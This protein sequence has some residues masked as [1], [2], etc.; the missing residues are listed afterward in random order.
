MPSYPQYEMLDA[1][2][3]PDGD[4]QFFGVN[5]YLEPEALPIGFVQ[6]AHDMRFDGNRATVRKGWDF[7][8][9]LSGISPAFTYVEGD[10]EV[11]G[12]GRYSDPDD[13]NKDWIVAVTKKKAIIWN[14][15][16]ALYV[17]Y[18]S[19]TVDYTDVNTSNERIAE[20]S[21]NLV[22]GTPIMFST[23]DTLPA[24]LDNTTTYYAIRDNA[25]EFK[26]A[27]SLANALAGT[28]INLSTQGAGTHTI[29]VVMASGH[30]CSIVQAFNKVYIF[31][32]HHRPMVWDGNTAATGYVVNSTFTLLSE[33]ASGVGDPFPSTSIA[34]YFNERMI[35]VQPATTATPTQS[36]TGA[37][38]VVMS[39]LLDPNNI[40]PVDGTYGGGEFYMNQGAAD[41]TVG[42]SPWLEHQLVVFNRRSV[43][44]IN[45]VHATSI[46]E[47][48]TIETRYGCVARRS[49]AQGG[50]Y[51]FFLSDDGVFTLSSARDSVT[52]AGL[53][54]SKVQGATTPLSQ[55][56]TDIISGLNYTDDVIEH[57]AGIVYKNK[58]YLAVPDGAATSNTTVLV[59]DI[60]NQSWVSKDTYP[61]GIK[62][63]VVM[64]Y[65]TEVRL[66]AIA[67]T[68][69]YMMEE[70]AGLDDS[71]R[72]IGSTSESTTT[73]I[74][75]KLKTRNYHGATTGTKKFPRIRIGADVT[76]SDAFTV[77]LNTVD[78]DRTGTLSSYTATATDDT[79]IKLR[80]RLRGYS[81]NVEVDVT[82]GSPAFRWIEVDAVTPGGNNQ[83]T[84]E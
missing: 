52:G 56:I 21:H 25:N 37:Q 45:N 14:E 81:C 31:G 36:V 53:T 66:F 17:N 23:T 41:W 39:D 79:A 50:G 58:Y 76:T 7:L 28:A 80:S 8:A 75:A 22:T 72:E 33:T 77:K 11:F 40:T 73:A 48:D 34:I 68:G 49:I 84:V 15:S 51:I 44:L 19:F 43:N 47:R 65:G 71:G 38:T 82:A 13:G 20:N 83:R 61:E 4:R 18:H 1:P 26:V 42:F 46:A 6:T 62:E 55:S 67:S 10:E 27:T 78:P 74:S 12:A 2:A 63:W 5:S 57:A 29:Q 24:E 16:S 59:Y 32:M 30:D 9:G 70:N 64:P 60:L 35:G 69:W 54:V 3:I